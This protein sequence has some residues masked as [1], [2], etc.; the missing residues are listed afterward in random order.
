MEAIP[1][2]LLLNKTRTGVQSKRTQFFNSVGYLY[3]YATCF[4]LYLGPLQACQYKNHI[5]ENT[6]QI[7]VCPRIH[8]FSI[9]FFSYPRSTAARKKVG[10]L[11]KRFVTFKTPAK[12]ER[13]VTCWNPG[14]QTRPVLNSSSLTPYAHFLAEL[15]SILLLGF[16]LFALVAALSQCL[17]SDN[18]YLSIN[19]TVFM[20]VTRISRYI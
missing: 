16:S 7:K 4:G 19:F 13:A 8:W 6:I 3:M 9:R 17:C 10:K 20:F 5:K 18:P 15:A 1:L 12:R 2:C 11:K 14:A